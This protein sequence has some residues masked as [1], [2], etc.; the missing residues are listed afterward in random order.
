MKRAFAEEIHCEP[1]DEGVVPNLPIADTSM[2]PLS[3]E[4]IVEN[5]KEI[6]GIIS[7]MDLAFFFMTKE[8]AILK[9]GNAVVENWQ[10]LSY[11][12]KDSLNFGMKTA[13]AFACERAMLASPKRSIAAVVKLDSPMKS[14]RPSLCKTELPCK[15]SDKDAYIPFLIDFMRTFNVMKPAGQSLD[16]NEWEDLLLRKAKSRIKVA[17]KE[18]L[19]RVKST[20][21]ELVYF[22]E[23][24]RFI[25][26]AWNR[27]YREV[28]PYIKGTREGRT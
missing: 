21:T 27:R 1:H 24:R 13:S 5:W 23:K 19:S 25:R 2:T 11:M 22:M 15:E 10:R 3:D 26:R 28:S 8:E 20:W 16:T 7:N 6:N 12:K 14:R 4:Q 9:A 17:E 18:T